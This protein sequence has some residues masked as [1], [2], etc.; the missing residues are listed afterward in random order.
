MK[1]DVNAIGILY[2]RRLSEDKVDYAEIEWSENHREFKERPG[3]QSSYKAD[4]V[5]LSMGFLHLQQ[6]PLFEDIDVKIN[7]RGNIEVDTNMMSRVP[8][9]FAAGDSV[10]G[11]SLVVTALHQGR[12]AAEGINRYLKHT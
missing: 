1:K 2:P 6:N 11:A 7:K 8:G 3:T 5:L 4:L 10:T 9:I 12:R